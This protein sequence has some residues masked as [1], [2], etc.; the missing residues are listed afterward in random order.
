MDAKW[1]DRGD[2]KKVE[3]EEGGGGRRW[4]RVD[5]GGQRWKWR[6]IEEWRGRW[7]CGGVEAE[8]R[9]RGKNVKYEKELK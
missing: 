5:G 2:G 8:E 3:V 4:M 9:G 1:R 6:R 7:M